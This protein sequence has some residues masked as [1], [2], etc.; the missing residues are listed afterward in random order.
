M[1]A[2]GVATDVRFPEALGVIACRCVTEGGSP[3][4]AASHAGGDWQMYCRWDGHDF[5]DDDALKRELVLVHVEH[6]VAVDPTLLELA[7]LPEDMGAERSAVGA[8][9]VRFEDKDD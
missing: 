4:L 7:D 5:D 6:L 3:V 1:P 8:P 2:G 9:W